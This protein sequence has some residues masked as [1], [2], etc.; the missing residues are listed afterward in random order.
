M[1]L[2]DVK[3]PPLSGTPGTDLPFAGVLRRLAGGLKAED[4][5]DLLDPLPAGPLE[6]AE[7]E[8]AAAVLVAL[9]EGSTGIELLLLRRA[10]HLDQHAGQIGLP[11]GRA[12]DMDA[13][14]AATA[15]REAAEEVCLDAGLVRVLGALRPLSVPVSFHRVL[16]VVGWLDAEAHVEVGSAESEACWFTPLETL[17]ACARP[18]QL[19][20][21]PAWEFPLPGARVW[22]MT[23]LV[24]GDLLERL[25][26]L[27]T[28]QLA[29]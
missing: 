9:R 27:P 14:P 28:G 15:L 6:C 25:A 13:H 24:V 22:G 1:P 2:A 20:G 18:V 23:A 17:V 26:A 19:R 16:P 3:C 12:A 8:R 5:A 7:G 4:V 10:G 29:G 11:G 21:Q